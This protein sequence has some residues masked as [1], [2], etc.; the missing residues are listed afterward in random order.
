MAKTANRSVVDTNRPEDDSG[1]TAVAEEMSVRADRA[2]QR[3][4]T[5]DAVIGNIDDLGYRGD[6]SRSR[7]DNHVATRDDRV[8]VSL[9]VVDL[10]TEDDS[11][12]PW[13]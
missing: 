3:T 12:L 7:S 11:G 4:N 10:N 6:R 1:R 9:L 5:D 13:T 8:R 2:R